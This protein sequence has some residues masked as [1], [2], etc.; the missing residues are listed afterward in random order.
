LSVKLKYIH[1]WNETRREHAMAYN[2]LLGHIK[3][4]TLPAIRKDSAHI[5]HLYV[6]RT[7]KRDALMHYLKERGVDVAIHYPTALPFLKAYEYLGHTA[8]DFPIAY[9]Y[10]EEIISL[11]MYPE[12]TKEQIEFVAKTIHTFFK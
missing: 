6:I 2:Q 10:Q 4:I 7:E 5:F 3:G 1:R 9:R 12:L 11:P 8:D